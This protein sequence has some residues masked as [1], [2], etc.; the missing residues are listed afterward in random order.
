MENNSKCK[1]CKKYVP[2]GCIKCNKTP[3]TF[4]RCPWNKGMSS[5]DLLAQNKEC[6]VSGSQQ[7]KY[8]KYP[9]IRHPNIY[10]V[11]YSNGKYQLTQPKGFYKHQTSSNLWLWQGFYSPY[12]SNS[13]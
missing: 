6:W 2:G 5:S 10:S 9:S 7:S 1:K 13:N 4:N 12:K 11:K 3:I 8:N